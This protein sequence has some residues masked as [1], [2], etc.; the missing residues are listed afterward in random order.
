MNALNNARIQDQH[1]EGFT[2]FAFPEAKSSKTGVS[3][4]YIP[5]ESKAWDVLLS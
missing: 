3:V 4:E 5:A 2:S 1:S